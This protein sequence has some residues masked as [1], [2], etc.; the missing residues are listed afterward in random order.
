MDSLTIP[1]PWKWMNQVLL[2]RWERSKS[3]GRHEVFWLLLKQRFQPI[4]IFSHPSCS[5]W[6]PEENGILRPD[7]CR[8]SALWVRLVHCFLTPS[9]R[10]S[11][12]GHAKAWIT[13]FFVF[14]FWLLLVFPFTGSDFRF[15]CFTKWRTTCSYSSEIEGFLI[16]FCFLFCS[17]CPSG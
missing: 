17:L 14:F 5:H 8:N 13:F 7:H 9:L 11:L 3:G 6:L 12:L 15:F 10:F 4:L 16:C 2:P 1:P